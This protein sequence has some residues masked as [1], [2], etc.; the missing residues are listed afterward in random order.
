MASGGNRVIIGT[1]PTFHNSPTHKGALLEQNGIAF[2][3][4]VSG[5]TGAY[6]DISCEAPGYEGT[7]DYGFLD[8]LSTHNAP[9]AFQA[10]EPPCEGNIAIVAQSGPTSGLHDADL[11]NW[12]CSVHQSFSV[13]PSD[14]T[15]LAIATDA[16]S[17]P[18]C[19][20]DVDT[21]SLACGQP[22]I[23]LAG[24]GV[25]I[26]SNI[27]LSP[28][29]ATNPVGTSHTVTAKIVD[30]TGAPV[31]GKTVTFTVD[32]GPN[33]GKTGT[34]VTNASGEAT[35]TYSDTGGAGAD[36]ISAVFTTDAGA[37]EKATATKTWTAST[38]DT[39]APTCSLTAKIAGPPAQIQVTLQDTGSGLNTVNV[40][41]SSNATTP[42]P[43]FTPGT[44]SPVVVT[45]TKI[46]QSKSASLALSATD[47]AGN[48]VSCDPVWGAA[49]HAVKAHRAHGRTR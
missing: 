43:P 8:G 14:F 22:Y 45:A 28:A 32:S 9:G 10:V 15:P 21:G 38:A 35:F 19:A 26:T 48:T 6:V 11:S 7:S 33:A 1:D 23:L 25:T 27:S 39:T 29:T 2:A 40:N 34:G 18:Y 46:D 42:V 4:A 3:G 31:A 30:S 24:G 12:E 49:K 36:S 20:N 41:T 37:Q 44:T 17:K 16:P 13:W 47:V 5:A